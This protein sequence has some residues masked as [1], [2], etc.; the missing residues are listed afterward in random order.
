MCRLRSQAIQSTISEFRCV[1]RSARAQKKWL[2]YRSF[3]EGC[4]QGDLRELEI[5]KTTR[6]DDALIRSGLR[7]REKFAVVDSHAVDF[8]PAG[9]NIKASQVCARE[10]VRCPLRGQ[11]PPRPP[12]ETALVPL[13]SD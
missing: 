10:V 6:R 1:P 4:G 13:T 2:T 11:Q 7:H 12:S 3:E 9:K 5:C 8:V